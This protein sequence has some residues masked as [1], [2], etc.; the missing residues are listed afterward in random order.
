MQ[1]VLAV[2]QCL[3][4]GAPGRGGG[5]LEHF[6][7]GLGWDWLGAGPCGVQRVEGCPWSLKFLFT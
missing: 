3:A 6:Q 5:E 2:A 1:S 7:E 4:C